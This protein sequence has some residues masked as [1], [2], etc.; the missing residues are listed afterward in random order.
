MS[1]RVLGRGIELSPWPVIAAD[2]HARGCDRLDAE[3]LRTRRNA[4]VEDFYDR[5]GLAPQDVAEDR[6]TYGSR[7]SDLEFP[8][9]PH[10]RISHE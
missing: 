2:A 6:R 5:L 10:I 7:L 3:W 9:Q 1:C 4:Q 8:P